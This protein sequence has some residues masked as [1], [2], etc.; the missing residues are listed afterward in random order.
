VA[1]AMRVEA[2]HS[3][4]GKRNGGL[5][6]MHLAAVAGRAQHSQCA[7]AGQQI[8]GL[9]HQNDVNRGGRAPLGCRVLQSEAEEGPLAF[10]AKRHPIW[11]EH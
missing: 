2:A 5:S 6:R 11:K 8:G 3:S 10:A 4:S 7:G 1:Q 9:R